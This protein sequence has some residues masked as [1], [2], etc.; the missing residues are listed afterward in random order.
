IK[1]QVVQACGA[2]PCAFL[3]IIVFPN[4]NMS[5]VR[6][7]YIRKYYGPTMNALGKW[8]KNRR[9]T[10]ELVEFLEFVSTVGIYNQKIIRRSVK[11]ALE[12]PTEVWA[13]AKLVSYSSG[14]WTY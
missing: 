10:S 4:E 1:D 14:L 8:I 12:Y 3:A 6:D 7:T 2:K 9:L 11:M 5:F 13:T